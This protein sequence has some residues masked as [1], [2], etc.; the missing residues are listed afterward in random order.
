MTKWHEP[1]RFY[2]FIKDI[3][4]ANLKQVES[5][6]DPQSQIEIAQPNSMKHS[7]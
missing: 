6:Q 2:T 4:S 1:L 5:R 3:F 7:Q